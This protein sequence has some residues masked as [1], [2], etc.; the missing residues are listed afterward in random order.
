MFMA[1][2]IEF[3]IPSHFIPKV[4]LLPQEQRGKVIAFMSQREEAAETVCTSAY[5][6]LRAKPSLWFDSE[7]DEYTDIQAP[8]GTIIFQI[9][10]SC[11]LPENSY[12]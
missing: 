11:M 8:E 3:Y 5:E 4:K 10:G 9:S 2:T 6:R 12:Y 1:Q 7:I